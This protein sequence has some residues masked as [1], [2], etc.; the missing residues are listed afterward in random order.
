MTIGATLSGSAE[1]PKSEHFSR[2]A[3]MPFE[4]ER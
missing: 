4:D 2:M 1:F 3:F